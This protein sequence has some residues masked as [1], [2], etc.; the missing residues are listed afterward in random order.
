[1]PFELVTF[2]LMTYYLMTF[3]LLTFVPILH[4]LI[5]N[6][7]VHLIPVDV[8]MPYQNYI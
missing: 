1:M 5:T 7:T 3:V 4:D 6:A 8:K 2:I